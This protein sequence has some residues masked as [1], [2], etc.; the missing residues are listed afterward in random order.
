LHL[1]LRAR[2]FERWPL[3]VT[4]YAE[5]VYRVWTRWIGQHLELK[6]G[7]GLREGLWVGLAEGMVA[8]ASIAKK[9]AAGLPAPPP[10]PTL[11]LEAPAPKG[12]H[13]LDVSHAPL[14]PQ[15]EKAQTLLAKP[16][17]CTLCSRA[18]PTLGASSL[19]CSSPSCNSITHLTCLATHF[20]TTE[21]ASSG[22]NGDSTSTPSILPTHGTCPSCSTPLLWQT[23]AQELSL[24]M[25]GA[26]EVAA[27]FKPVRTRKRKSDEQATAGAAEDVEEEEEGEDSELELQEDEDVWHQLSDSASEVDAPV[28]VPV[29]PSPAA[30]KKATPALRKPGKVVGAVA[31]AKGK[32]KGKA[33]ATGA[34]VVVEDSDEDEVIG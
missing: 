3:K 27:L 18:L 32:G 10:E 8:T 14:K 12:I 21:K 16:Q 2:S 33:R 28:P 25:R 23:L 29:L 13:A 7:D 22:D 5:D 30:R 1:L 24:R 15:L 19:I 26:K 20:L 17:K 4:F 11:T 6:G 9:V 31:G 34:E